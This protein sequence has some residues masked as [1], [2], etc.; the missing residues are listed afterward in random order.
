MAQVDQAKFTKVL[1]APGLATTTRAPERIETDWRSVR[2]PTTVRLA[3][4]LLSATV[5]T[6]SCTWHGEFARGNQYQPSESPRGG[7]CSVRAISGF[8]WRHLA[9][10]TFLSPLGFPTC[11]L[12]A[13]SSCRDR[14]RCY[15][16]GTTA[17]ASP[18]RRF[19]WCRCRGVATES[20]RA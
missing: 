15:V 11:N 2:S 10:W 8:F 17:P 16:L 6:V 3:E 12:P 13:P 20:R 19:P 9:R 14:A 18:R 4:A 5:R 1:Q 7:D